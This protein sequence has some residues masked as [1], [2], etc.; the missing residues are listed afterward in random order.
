MGKR[1]G[2]MER[3][4]MGG[5]GGNERTKRRKGIKIELIQERK[6]KEEKEKETETDRQEE[7]E[8]K[9]KETNENREKD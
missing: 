8:K 9:N 4:G 5:Q 3:L 7:S 2:G 6:K 1:V